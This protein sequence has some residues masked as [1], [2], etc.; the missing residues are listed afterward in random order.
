MVRELEIPERACDAAVSALAAVMAD[1]RA[2]QVEYAAV[3][4]VRAAAPIIVAAELRRLAVR[5]NDLSAQIWL[6][7]RADELDP[8]GDESQ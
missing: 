7:Q 3:G 2:G 5:T 8:P 4:V 6:R 1:K